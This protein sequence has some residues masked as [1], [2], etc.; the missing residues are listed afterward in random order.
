MS[1]ITNMFVAPLSSDHRRFRRYRS[2]L[3]LYYYYYLSLVIH[4]YLFDN[5]CLLHFLSYIDCYINILHKYDISCTEP[6]DPRIQTA[7]LLLLKN[8][9][10]V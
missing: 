10:E 1:R 4:V 5:L 2:L 9:K 7:L 6:V 8:V 3:L